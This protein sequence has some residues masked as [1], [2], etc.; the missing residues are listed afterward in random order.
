MEQAM[1]NFRM[2][3]KMKLD[4]EK[5]CKK[6]GL[7]MTAAFTMFAAKVIN[8]KRIPFEVSVDPFYSETNMKR[9][10]KSIE[11]ME[12]TGGTIHKVN[13]DD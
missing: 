6:M 10:R 1:V 12:K 4:M 11:Q 9:L 5:I 2:D 7:S 8:E 3:R 13:L